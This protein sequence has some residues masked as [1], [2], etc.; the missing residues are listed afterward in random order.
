MCF[1]PF[2]YFRHVLI[3]GLLA[4]RSRA[5]TIRQRPFSN[6]ELSRAILKDGIAE[7]V[8]VKGY[9][10]RG[11]A[12]REIIHEITYQCFNVVVHSVLALRLGGRTIRSVARII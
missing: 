12:R 4:A 11:E 6:P 5:V 1:K 7:K 2:D 9:L 3:I 10:V 8:K